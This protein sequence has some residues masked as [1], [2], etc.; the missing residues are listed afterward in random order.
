VTA[1][2]ILWSAISLVS[3]L[4]GVGATLFAF[5]RFKD[6]GWPEDRAGQARE[7]AFRHPG[8]VRLTS[9]QRSTVWYFL[10]VAG[11]FLLQGLVGGA[12]AH[13]HAEP[14]RFFGLDISTWFPYHLTRTWHLQLALF[15]V[16]TSYL[17]I[18]IFLAPMIAGK[19]PPHQDK[20]AGV[21]FGALV[22][23]VLGSLTGEML[24][25]RDVIESPSTAWWLGSL[26]V[27]HQPAGGQLLGNRH[28]VYGQPRTCRDDGRLRHAGDWVLR[29]R[30]RVFRSARPRVGASDEVVVLVPQRRSRMDGVREPL[31]HRCHPVLRRTRAWLLA[32]A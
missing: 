6:L 20:L 10:V 19:E 12:N 26:G 15:F 29:L 32:R 28:A 4:L 23:V 7:L 21:L 14:T 8:E 3:L 24:S 9:A 5:G 25:Y 22:V 18:G 13:Y 31:S 30:R 11:L 1:D 27:S 16:A 2:A 17:E